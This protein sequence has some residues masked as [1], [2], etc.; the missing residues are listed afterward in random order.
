M[1]TFFLTLALFFICLFQGLM[2]VKIES[3]SETS[4][5]D[6]SGHWLRCGYAGLHPCRRGYFWRYGVRY[7]GYPYGFG[8]RGCYRRCYRRGFCC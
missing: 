3:E 2:G 8:Y 4:A 5:S 7:F 1:K 6:K